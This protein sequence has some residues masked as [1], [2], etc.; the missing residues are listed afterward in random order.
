[1]TDDQLQEIKD[2][3]E[4]MVNVETMM[5]MDTAPPGPA[6]KKDD[7]GDDQ[8]DDTEGDDGEGDEPPA[9][10]KPKSRRLIAG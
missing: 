3:L 7:A 1:V 9:P 8:G 6:D 2:E 10:A 5:M 4:T